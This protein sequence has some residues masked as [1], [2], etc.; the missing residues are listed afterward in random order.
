M[1]RE[2]VVSRMVS[3]RVREDDYAQMM[4]SYKRAKNP[5]ESVAAFFRRAVIGFE[6][7]TDNRI[8]FT[9]PDGRRYA[10]QTKVLVDSVDELT[11]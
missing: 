10:V 1:R 3:F 5:G 6:P 11:H 2:H 9:G 8:I 7:N 4:R